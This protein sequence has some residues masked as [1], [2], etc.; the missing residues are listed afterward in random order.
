MEIRMNFTDLR[1]KNNNN[2]RLLALKGK[3]SCIKMTEYKY[4]NNRLDII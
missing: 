4:F 3:A 1:M 2:A